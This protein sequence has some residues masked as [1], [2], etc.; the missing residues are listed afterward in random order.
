MGFS[1]FHGNR[2]I[3]RRL[4]DMV[5]RKHFPHAMILSGAEGAGKYTLALMLA[6]ALVTAYGNT[7]VERLFTYVSSLLYG[8]YA[9]FVVLALSRF[10]GRIFSGFATPAPLSGSC[11]RPFSRAFRMFAGLSSPDLSAALV[12]PGETSPSGQTISSE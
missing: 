7:S 6:I 4:R 9:L 1:D 10:G 8:V 3:I 11:G 2:E 12:S 5:A